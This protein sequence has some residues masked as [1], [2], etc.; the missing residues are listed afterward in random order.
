MFVCVKG[1]CQLKHPDDNVFFGK[2]KGREL[3]TIDQSYHFL[4]KILPAMEL[5]SFKKS[6]VS[7]NVL[8]I[9]ATGNLGSTVVRY[10]DNNHNVSVFVRSEEKLQSVLIKRKNFE[11]NQKNFYWK[12]S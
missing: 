2:I 10:I 6:V 1:R 5:N 11:E 12:L 8:V 3:K 7:L 9:G 4:V